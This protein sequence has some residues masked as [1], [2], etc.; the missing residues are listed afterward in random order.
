MWYPLNSCP[1]GCICSLPCIPGTADGQITMTSCTGE[2]DCTH[3]DTAFFYG[4]GDMQTTSLKVTRDEILK[5]DSRILNSNKLSL[6]LGDAACPFN[7]TLNGMEQC[8]TFFELELCLLAEAQGICGEFGVKRMLSTPAQKV[9]CKNMDGTDSCYAVG[10]Y[11]CQCA[12]TCDY[13][14]RRF[15]GGKYD[16][17]KIEENCSF[18]YCECRKPLPE[19]CTAEL[20]GTHEE[21]ICQNIERSTPLLTKSKTSIMQI[22]QAFHDPVF[23]GMLTPELQNEIKTSCTVCSATYL[24][25][26]PKVRKQ[27]QQ[28][29]KGQDLDL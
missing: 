27:L 2:V 26:V 12:G 19:S 1:P 29:L 8:L 24:R 23:L 16:W 3:D 21:V 13:V 4:L 18:S 5:P 15:E 20:E 11:D 10:W 25:M 7:G 6:I 22:K 28:F 14:C 17:W 9:K